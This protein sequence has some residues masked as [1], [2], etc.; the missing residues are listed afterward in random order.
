MRYKC[1]TRMLDSI[2]TYYP[3]IRVI[4]ADDTPTEWQVLL[5]R[6]K[7]PTVYQYIMP[8]YLGWFAGRALVISQV[9][10]DYFVWVDDDFI[11]NHESNLRYMLDVLEKTGMLLYVTV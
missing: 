9:E 1:L 8:E 10:T 6:A 11:F 5:D 3:R 7:Y 4:I 2:F